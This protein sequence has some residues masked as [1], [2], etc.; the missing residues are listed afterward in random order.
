MDIRVETRLNTET[1]GQ[2][3]LQKEPGT[4]LAIQRPSDMTVR[5]T[6][7]VV[8]DD[9]NILDFLVKVLGNDYFVI[10]TDSGSQA[11]NLLR[12]NDPDLVVSDIMM[13]DIDGIELCRRIKTTFPQAISL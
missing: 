9:S 3:Q 11:L 2:S 13:A 1:V 10:S 12:N 6:V 5:H 8:D 4:D 7:M